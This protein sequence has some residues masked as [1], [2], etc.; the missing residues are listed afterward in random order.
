MTGPRANRFLEA[1]L[2]HPLGDGH[3][4]GVDHGQAADDEG[5][6][7]G[8]GGDCRKE[9]APGVEACHQGARLGRLDAWNLGIDLV[10]ELIEIDARLA[11]DRCAVDELRRI[12]AASDAGRQ[13]L[14]EERLAIGKAD[15]RPGIGRRLRLGQDPDHGEAMVDEVRRRV[16]RLDGEVDA[17]PNLLLELGG[18]V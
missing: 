9:R 5:N 7:R 13:S 14:L 1:D 2:T 15:V 16:F 10:G 18:E 11:V 4:H 8:A 6:Q 17:L 12:D 3:Q